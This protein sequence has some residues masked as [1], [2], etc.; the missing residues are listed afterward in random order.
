MLLN[1]I[2]SQKEGFDAA[3]VKDIKLDFKE[4]EALAP[5]LQ[6]IQDLGLANP[7]GKSII[8]NADI[9]P[10]P[11]LRKGEPVPPGCFLNQCSK[12]IENNKVRFAE[13]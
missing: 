6:L 3:L 4:M 5:T 12:F 13:W 10:G 9:L 8:L 2:T 1:I 11:G 7:H